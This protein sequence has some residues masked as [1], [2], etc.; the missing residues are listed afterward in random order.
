MFII[1]Y[2]QNIL[3]NKTLFFLSLVSDLTVHYKL[4]AFE[5]IT[6]Q[7]LEKHSTPYSCCQAS[8]KL[9]NPFAVLPRLIS[10]QNLIV[11]SLQ[12]RAPLYLFLYVSPTKVIDFS[13]ELYP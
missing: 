6:K 2:S 7:L 12:I 8:L 4:G 1:Y 9:S 11:A 13:R 5:I 3:E 10:S